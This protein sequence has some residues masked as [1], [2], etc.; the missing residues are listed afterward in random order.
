MNLSRTLHEAL[1]FIAVIYQLFDE[2]SEGTPVASQ[3]G[4]FQLACEGVWRF[5]SM[6]VF[7]D[8]Q[9][10]TSISLNV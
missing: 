10:A 6:Q 5:C 1:D 2:G 7:E 9:V 8:S 3:S 4:I